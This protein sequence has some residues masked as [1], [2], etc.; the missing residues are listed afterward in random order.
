MPCLFHKFHKNLLTFRRREWDLTSEQESAAELIRDLQHENQYL[1]DKERIQVE[2]ARERDL[3]C[4]DSKLQQKNNKVFNYPHFH[5]MRDF[6]L[7]LY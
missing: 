5:T 6:I 2:D 3:H 7:C 1:C 4:D